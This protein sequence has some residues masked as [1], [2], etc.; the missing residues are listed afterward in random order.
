[1]GLIVYTGG[2]FSGKTTRLIHFYNTFKTLKRIIFKPYI[3]NRT[4]GE[5]INSHDDNKKTPA[6]IIKNAKDVY[7]IGK[8]YS[9]VFID[10]AQFFSP[11]DVFIKSVQK[12][13]DN[14]TSVMASCLDLDYKREPFEIS[15][16]LMAMAAIVNKLKTTCSVCENKEARYSYKLNQKENTERIQIGGKEFYKPVC[17]NCYLNLNKK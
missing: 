12:L 13:L 3:D 17:L 5:F 9:L 11:E 1:M 15:S 16:K 10:E 7:T 8:N 6:L 14:G 4:N 2:M